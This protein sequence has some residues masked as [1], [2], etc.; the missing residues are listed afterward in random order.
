ML[1][2]R[3]KAKEVIEKAEEARRNNVD[4]E[5]FE[6]VM[7]YLPPFIKNEARI[8]SHLLEYETPLIMRTTSRILCIGLPC[9]PGTFQA[10]TRRSAPTAARNGCRKRMH[11]DHY[12]VRF[13]VV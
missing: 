12:V 7:E 9:P 2:R 1:D 3:E 6:T 10:P 11:Q 5:F 4:N 8:D 13:V